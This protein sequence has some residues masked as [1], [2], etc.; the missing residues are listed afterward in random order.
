M[1]VGYFLCFIVLLLFVMISEEGRELEK[2]REKKKHEAIM[3]NIQN[4]LK[5][6]KIRVKIKPEKKTK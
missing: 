1:F 2:E 3:T 5:T 6:N 4:E